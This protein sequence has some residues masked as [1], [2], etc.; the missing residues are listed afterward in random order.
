[1][2]DSVVKQA[3]EALTL[4][5]V[6]ELAP[7]NSER[8]RR[9]GVRVSPFREDRKPSFSIFGGLRRYQDKSSGLPDPAGGVWSFV[10]ECRPEWSKQDV[11]RY[12]VE[13]AGLK[14]DEGGQKRPDKSIWQYREE[15]RARNA[16]AKEKLYREASRP[17]DRP[18]PLT[19][20]PEF[21]SAHYFDSDA[22]DDARCE[23]VAVKR[24]WP[25]DWVFGIYGESLMTFPR[26]PWSE[27]R[28]PAFMVRNADGLVIGYHQRIWTEGDG[29]AWLY[30]PY[31]PKK[32]FNPFTRQLAEH[33]AGASGRLVQPLP[34]WIGLPPAH[35][36]LWIICE[37]QWDAI[38]IF[39]L[40]G[41]FEDL[42]DLPICVLGLRGAEAGPS[43]FLSHYQDLLRRHKPQIWL[44]PDNDP[45]GASWD[46]K[47]RATVGARPR[48][49]TFSDQLLELVGRD[50]QIPVSRVPA[51]YGKDFNDYYRAAAPTR[52]SILAQLERLF[53]SWIQTLTH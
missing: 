23:R 53:T 8:P 34:F 37:G 35:A 26:L 24:G 38:T 25:A 3:L 41:G 22:R 27:K 47:G 18:A 48:R 14:W 7:D 33:A 15:Q 45:A 52:Q 9:D 36:G 20:W 19:P 39:G 29:P 10:K 13:R 28:F 44:M 21:V 16:Q 2:A 46:G 17:L 6:W 51:K 1:M 4:A 49:A 43:V 11:A 30:V 31:A 32:A 50:R 40:L 42:F 12:V 5:D